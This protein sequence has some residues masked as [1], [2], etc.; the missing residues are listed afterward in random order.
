MLYDIKKLYVIVIVFISRHRSGEAVHSSRP[1]PG[2]SFTQLLAGIRPL[3]HDQS[4]S[5]RSVHP[6]SQQ[7][8][9]RWVTTRVPVGHVR[10]GR[11]KRIVWERGWG[12]DVCKWM[13]RLG[14]SSG[15]TVGL[16]NQKNGGLIPCAE[17]TE[18]QS[19]S[20]GTTITTSQGLNQCLCDEAT[21][22]TV[23]LFRLTWWDANKS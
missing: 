2:S 21:V 19:A 4:V 20:K 22:S 6:T 10:K 15:A 14:C 11:R 12:S 23:L 16:T 1:E 5:W 3:P 13:C 18:P 9:H 17:D 8:A 7:P